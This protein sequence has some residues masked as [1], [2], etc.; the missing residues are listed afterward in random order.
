MLPAGYT[1]SAT[2]RA[3]WNGLRKLL[4]QFPGHLFEIQPISLQSAWNF[5]VDQEGINEQ[6][7]P[8]WGPLR[9]VFSSRDYTDLYES[10]SRGQA[11]DTSCFHGQFKAESD[12]GRPSW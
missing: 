7:Q 11:L 2:N 9:V 8:F 1:S 5:F 10:F 4:L 6:S 12:V 3:L